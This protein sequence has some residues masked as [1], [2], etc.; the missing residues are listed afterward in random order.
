M[1]WLAETGGTASWA[2]CWEEHASQQSLPSK[3]C[4]AALQPSS[5][6]TFRF[7][8]FGFEVWRL[9]GFAAIYRICLEEFF[10]DVSWATSVYKIPQNPVR[11][12]EVRFKQDIIDL[13]RSKRYASRAA[14]DIGAGQGHTTAA[15]AVNFAVVVAIEKYW[16]LGNDGNDYHLLSGRLLTSDGAPLNNVV[17]MHMDTALPYAF[18]PL[19]DQNFSA[20][21]IDAQHSFESVVRETFHVLRSIPCCVETIIYH[22][23]CFEEVFQAIF[24]FEQAGLLVFQKDCAIPDLV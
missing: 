11:L 18:A 22:D 5:A 2:S 8:R 24:F 9:H 4:K 12:A 10:V 6:P 7:W 16:D 23:F 17:R 3:R 14:L 15:L 20:A 13:F 21:V 1:P 19:A